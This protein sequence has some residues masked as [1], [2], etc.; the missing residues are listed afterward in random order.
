MPGNFHGAPEFGRAHARRYMRAL[1]LSAAVTATVP[2]VRS[3]VLGAQP[4]GRVD[5][6]SQRPFP[7]TSDTAAWASYGR[8]YTNQRWSLL[9]QITA[10]SVGAL[11]PAWQY[12][13][14]IRHSFEASPVVVGGTMFVSTPLNHVVALDARTGAKRWEYAHPLGKTVACCGPVNRGV[15]VADGRVFMGTL[16]ARL[17]AL[18]AA[19]GAPRWAAAVGQP[20]SGYSITSAPLAVGGLVVTGV[21]GGEY[22]VRGYVSAYDAATGRLVWR[23]HT[24]PAPADGGWWGPWAPTDPFGTPLHRDLAREHA[25]SARYADAWRH[26]GGP[27]WQTPAY[28]ATL[29]V[30][31]FT[32]G[33]PSPD[34][35]GAV[36]PGDNRYTNSIVALELRTGRLRWATQVVPHDVWDL[37][38]ASPA[39]LVD[40]RD[41]TGTTVPAVAEAGKTG[42]VYVLD[43]RTG[44]PIRRSEPFVPHENMFAP[45]AGGDTVRMA[46]GDVGGSQWSP[47][48]YHPGLGYL[49]VLGIH[50]PTTY[51]AGRQERNPP[52]DWWGGVFA[53]ERPSGILSA[54]DLNTGRIAWQHRTPGPLVGGAVATA[55]DLVFV[56]TS[57]RELLAFDART[58]A[59]RWRHQ[60]E[61]G[62]NAPPITYALDGRQ[63]VAVA[64]GGN[65]TLHTPMGD[66]LLVFALPTTR[67]PARPAGG[68]GGRA[69]RGAASA[70]PPE[71]RP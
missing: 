37:D 4:P 56:G 48:A 24:I 66:A 7:A 55:G 12:R 28:D 38:P 45:L 1:L 46:P 50:A 71:G 9:A 22:G 43:R 44:R 8:D 57:E 67:S 62:V 15:A 11:A 14:G 29:G 65:W 64:A 6:R 3:P 33:N 52:A 51:M 17:V 68:A 16:D 10:A 60:A 34:L 39:V 54:I 18:D 58:G 36:R 61:A 19:T 20:D 49:Y 27:V 47:P 32:V 31:V 40:V 69:A 23:W 59:V 41:S 25:D 35:D 42:W 5:L 63:F 30:I 26:G 21:S 13:T 70:A 53:V 2:S